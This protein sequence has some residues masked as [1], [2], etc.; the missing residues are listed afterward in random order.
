MNPR[1]AITFHDSLPSTSD[2]ARALAASGAAHGTV[3]AARRQTAGRGRLGRSWVSPPGNLHASFLL[4]YAIPPARQAELGFA[5]ALAVADL[6]DAHLDAGPRAQLKWPNDVL[7]DGQKIAGI[8]LEADSAPADPFVVL[9]IGINLAHAPPNLP[10]P[11]TSLAALGASPPAPEAALDRLAEL[12]AARLAAWEQHGFAPIRAAWRS[13]GPAPGTRLRVT[14]GNTSRP[15]GFQE[16]DFE[17][18]AED[19]AL[20]LWTP[21]GQLRVTAGVVSC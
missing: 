15:T 18:L 14:A 7:V 5:A 13:R 20:V 10:Y 4:R 6:V 1:F 17:D 11:V 16:G 3:I 19:G 21:D 12:L 9:G 8:L 2:T